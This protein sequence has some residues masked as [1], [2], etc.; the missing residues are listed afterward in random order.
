MY[1][2]MKN[3][4]YAFLFIHPAEH[5]IGELQARGIEVAEFKKEI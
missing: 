3:K 1:E 5:I 4:H 2:I